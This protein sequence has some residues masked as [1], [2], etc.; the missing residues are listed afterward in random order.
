MVRSKKVLL[1]L[2][3]SVLIIILDQGSKDFAS[4]NLLVGQSVY[5]FTFLNFTLNYN[6]GAAFGFLNSEN[7]WQIIFFSVIS[8]T[9]SIILIIWLSR[10][11]R[12][13]IVMIQG[14][15]LIIGGALSNCI[16]RIRYGY[17]MDFIDVHVKD[18]HFAI[19]NIADS[20]ICIGVFLL[21]VNMLFISQ[22]KDHFQ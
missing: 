22:S 17:V 10:I 7:G 21:I 19:F 2:W 12:S 20:T 16:D 11:P 5:I 6:F 3:L 14:L 9:I 15:A 13:N 1:W 18:W 4:H 8:L